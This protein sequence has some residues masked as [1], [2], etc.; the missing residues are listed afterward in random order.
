MAQ[1]YFINKD[2][3]SLHLSRS[4]PTEQADIQR[5]VQTGRKRPRPSKKLG[6]RPK[7][8]QE[9]KPK[10]N[11]RQPYDMRCLWE[12]T[13]SFI[14]ITSALSK[15]DPFDAAVVKLDSTISGLLHYYVYVKGRTY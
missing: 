13:P 11:T 2:E 6:T 5:Y 7:A 9:S 12:A 1:F 15:Q 8:A 4:K 14:P 10:P 3:K